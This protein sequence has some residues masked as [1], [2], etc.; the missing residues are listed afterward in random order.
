MSGKPITDPQRLS[1]LMRRLESNHLI[2]NLITSILQNL[3]NK[4]K[5]NPSKV[6]VNESSLKFDEC[7]KKQPLGKF[8]K[9]QCINKK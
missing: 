5:R 2:Q 6:A 8:H 3:V 9:I 7:T 4:L 1:L